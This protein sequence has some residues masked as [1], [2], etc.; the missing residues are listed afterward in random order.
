MGDWV[1][2][3]N[4]CPRRPLCPAKWWGT[5]WGREERT[6]RVKPRPQ[7]QGRVRR[8]RALGATGSSYSCG[9]RPQPAVWGSARGEAC[10]EGR[11]ALGGQDGLIGGQRP[12]EQGLGELEDICFDHSHQESEA[13]RQSS[14]ARASWLLTQSCTDAPDLHTFL[15]GALLAPGSLASPAVSFVHTGTSVQITKAPLS[16]A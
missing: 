11:G 9:V 10:R 16:L 15:G 3:R 13:P 14:S 5:S 12:L 4:S 6:A 1:Q 7:P 2:G 8:G